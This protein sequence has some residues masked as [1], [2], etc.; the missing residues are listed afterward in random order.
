VNDTAV[1]LSPG[2]VD[3]VAQPVAAAAIGGGSGT[4]GDGVVGKIIANYV[5]SLKKERIMLCVFL[6][7]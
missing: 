5:A 2:Q 3:E 1:V 4:D 6:G 7:L